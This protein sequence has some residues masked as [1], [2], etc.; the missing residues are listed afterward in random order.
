VQRYSRFDQTI[1]WDHPSECHMDESGELKQSY[2]NWRNKGFNNTHFVRYPV[3][4]NNMHKCLYSLWNGEKLDYI[5]SRKKIY[6]PVYIDLARRHQKFQELKA[7]LDR[8]VNLLIM[9]PD[10]PRQESLQYYKDK[11]GVQDNFI[12]GKTMVANRENLTLMLNDPKH[13]FG[14]GYCLSSALLDIDLSV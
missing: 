9:E 1:T 11:Y 4:M 8:G 13:A 2:F 12:E 10:G 14:H 7:L 3:G 5:Q 6:G